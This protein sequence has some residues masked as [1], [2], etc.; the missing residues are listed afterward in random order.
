M[1]GAGAAPPIL[2][3]LAVWAL[4]AEAVLEQLAVLCSA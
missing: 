1:Q 3:G 2:T 4:R